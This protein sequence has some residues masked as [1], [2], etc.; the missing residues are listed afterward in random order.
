MPIKNSVVLITGGSQGYGKAAAKAFALKGAKVIIAARRLQPLKEALK[1]TGSDSYIC[2]DVTNPDDWETIAYKHVMQ[3]YGRLDVLVN[4]AGGGVAIKEIEN[5]TVQQIDQSIAL[6]LKSVIYGSRTFAELMKN[7][8]SGTVINVASVCAKHAWPGWSVYAA[9]KWGVLG[10]SKNLYVEVQP[11]GVRVTC[12]IP[13]AGA[14]D[15]MQHAG[16]QNMQMRLSAHDIAQAMVN[17]CE[18]PEHVVV[19]EMT[20]WGSDQSVIPL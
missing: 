19:E 14:T 9:A 10:F 11:Y 15:F 20:V 16:Q 2:M 3:Q 13:G 4:N 17:I 1:E 7:Q 8:R 12:L 6:N 18:L 5:Q